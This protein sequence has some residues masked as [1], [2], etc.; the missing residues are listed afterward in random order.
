MENALVLCTTSTIINENHFPYISPDIFI[1][2]K[3]I[4]CYMPIARP[5]VYQ[6]NMSHHK[7][8]SLVRQDSSSLKA[9]Q[10]ISTQEVSSDT[11][12]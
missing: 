10:H 9:R 3:I 11:F 6:K 1:F 12:P 5:E 8:S 4:M 7:N 2:Q